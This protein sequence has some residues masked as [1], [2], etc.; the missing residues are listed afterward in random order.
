M[1]A[2]KGKTQGEII[3]GWAGVASEEWKKFKAAYPHKS[4]PGDL[5]EALECIITS[6]FVELF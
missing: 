2:S 3:N 1:R 5:H 4:N 6:R